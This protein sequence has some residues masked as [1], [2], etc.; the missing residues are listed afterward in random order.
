MDYRPKYK[1]RN[2]KLLEENLDRMLTDIN[3]SNNFL[4]L[5]PKTKEIEISN[6]T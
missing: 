4:D 6:G 3:C 5:S 2:C 1:T